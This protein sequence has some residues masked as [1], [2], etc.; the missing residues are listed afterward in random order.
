MNKAG[1]TVPG[2]IRP[3]VIELLSEAEY[4]ERR[5]RKRGPTNR[6]SAEQAARLDRSALRSVGPSYAD[7][8]ERLRARFP[9]AKTT[10]AC[11]RWYAV[12]MRDGNARFP[13]ALPQRRPR[14]TCARYQVGS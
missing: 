11:L 14:S 3:A 6:L 5:D 8:L 4:C 7:L 13:G 1:E 10:A 2:A 12:Q 9:Y